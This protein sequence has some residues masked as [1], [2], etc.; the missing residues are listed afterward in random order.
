MVGKD[1]LGSRASRPPA[2]PVWKVADWTQP[3]F[4]D[5]MVKPEVF[6]SYTHRDNYKLTDD[7][8]GWIDRFH[9][10]LTAR[11]NTLC[12][13]ETY[14]WR[15]EKIKGT[16]LL[17]PTIAAA[18]QGAT[19][20]VS[21]ISPSYVNSEWCTKELDLFV[22][23]ADKTRNLQ[24]GTQARVVKVLKTPV[25]GHSPFVDRPELA[26]SLGYQFYRINKSGAPDE[27]DPRLGARANQDFLN[28]VN[29]LAHALS[30]LLELCGAPRA[31]THVVPPSGKTVYVATTTADLAPQVDRVRWEL[32]QFGHT[33]LPL[34]PTALLPDYPDRIRELLSRC[35]MSI[36]AVGAIYGA[37]PEGAERSVIELQY[38]IAAEQVRSRSDFVRLPWMPPGLE[39]HDTRLATF[40]AALGEDPKFLVAPVEQLKTSVQDLLKPKPAQLA[41]AQT[42]D[43]ATVYFIFDGS[44]AAAAAPIE[45]QLYATG[46]EV[47]HALA[48]GDERDLRRDHE[49][50]LQL[51][52]AVL[53]YYGQ[54]NEFWLRAK[55]RD[56][57]KAFGYGRSRPFVAR[58]VFLADPARQD[59]DRFRSHDVIAIDGHG[60]FAPTM[61]NAFLDV[62]KSNWSSSG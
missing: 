3:E 61:L 10:A 8:L 12:G 22:T 60:P 49:E 27:F 24:V 37:I 17:T 47:I 15:D 9:E 14:V 28:K 7:Q 46:L 45:E 16:D 44:D 55:L 51:C 43:A 1:L 59:K 21:V 30:D 32:E 54:P 42:S 48:A 5:D 25:S 6:I 57:Q 34:Q 19:I 13:R 29:E 2:A 23:A 31:R 38:T 33:V 52:D 18:V 35:D 58:A 53:I 41:A 20:L 40:V 39:I 36:H 26:E 50:N 56:L 4:C 62:I 11:L